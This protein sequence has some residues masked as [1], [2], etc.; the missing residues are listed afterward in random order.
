MLKR[1]INAPQK[2]KIERHPRRQS[3]VDVVVVSVST[4]WHD[5]HSASDIFTHTHTHTR[6]G[7][8]WHCQSRDSESGRPTRREIAHLDDDARVL[9]LDTDTKINSSRVHRAYV[10]LCWN[11][12]RWV[13][14]MGCGY[15]FETRENEK[16]DEC[17]NLRCTWTWMIWRPVHSTF[18]HTFGRGFCFKLNVCRK[19]VRPIEWTRFQ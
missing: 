13:P 14:A 1:R 11:V 4:Q 18:I 9:Q 10:C 6:S 7:E 17:D 15:I 8:R 3:N 12:E 5:V 2:A 19:W 16:A